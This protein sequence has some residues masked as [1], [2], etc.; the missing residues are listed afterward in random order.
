MVAFPPDDL[1]EG[2][3]VSTVT[4][5]RFRDRVHGAVNA[6]KT[7]LVTTVADVTSVESDVSTLQADVTS[8]QSDITTLQ[9]DVSTAQS[10]ITTLQSDVSSNDTDITA[11]QALDTQSWTSWSPTL[12]NGTVGNG[13]VTARYRILGGTMTFHIQWVLGSTSTVGTNPKFLTPSAWRLHDATQLY[14][15]SPAMAYDSSAAT[16]YSGVAGAFDSTD[17][18]LSTRLI[19]GSSTVSATSPFTWASGDILAFSGS[20]EVE[21]V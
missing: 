14:V 6:L 11:L 17:N 13:T 7:Q 1:P 19:F 20:V 18:V 4:A 9:T 15:V 2:M 3:P 10:D 21:A 8:A 16:F 12:V 5:N